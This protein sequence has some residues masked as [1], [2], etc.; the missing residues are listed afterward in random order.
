LFS[1]EVAEAVAVVHGVSE[2]DPEPDP[3]WQ[4]IFSIADR[5]E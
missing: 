4:G 1:G 5:L 2:V 3:G